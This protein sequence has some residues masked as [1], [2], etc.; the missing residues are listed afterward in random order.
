MPP[1]SRQFSEMEWSSRF[2]RARLSGHPEDMLLLADEAPAEG[3][4]L[5]AYRETA[6]M[7]AEQGQRQLAAQA[8]VAA[9]TLAPGD[10]DCGK[11]LQRLAKQPPGASRDA[12]PGSIFLFS[13]HMIDKPGRKPPRFPADK[14]PLAA[15]AIAAQLDELEAGEPDIAIASGAC[16][17]DLLFAEAALQRGCRLQIYLPFEIEEFLFHS[18]SFAGEAWKQRF[19][20]AARHPQTGMRI[21]P[22]EL[23][24]PPEGVNPYERVNIWMLYA[25]L[26]GGVEQ[27]HFICLWNRQ[28]GDGRGGTR[29][30][31]D[32]VAARGGQVHVLDTRQIFQLEAS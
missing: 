28:G 24:P 25:A 27:V 30:L 12:F 7:L 9:L 17:G 4:Q 16:G 22:R 21:M 15:Q 19:A 8:C 29:H 26:G 31:H 1:S 11:L 20:A 3:L 5:W 18:V 32:A 23:G 10:R 13:G 2:T 6:E 14:V